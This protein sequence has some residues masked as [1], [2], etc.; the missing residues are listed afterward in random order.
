[1]STVM[2]FTSLR[3]LLAMNLFASL[4][5]AAGGQQAVAAPDPSPSSPPKLFGRQAERLAT[6]SASALPSGF[7]DERVA[8]GK[9]LPAQYQLGTPTAVAFLPDGRLLVA[10]K[11][12]RLRLVKD[13]LVQPVPA[14]DWTAQVY[15]NGDAGLI[16]VAVDQAFA[17]NGYIYL[18]YTSDNPREGRVARFTMTGDTAIP[19]S[20]LVLLSTIADHDTH[21]IDSVR[22]GADGLLYASDGD[23][24]PF[25]TATIDATRS[26]QADQTVGKVYRMTTSGQGIPANPFWTGNPNDAASK[27]FGLGLRN[28]FRFTVRP[29]G[30]VIVGDVGWNTWEE[31]DRILPNSSNHNYGWPCYEGGNN[32]SQ[33][34]PAFSNFAVCQ[35][36]LPQ[37]TG[38]VTAPV[39]AYDHTV[40]SS[41]TGGMVYDGTAFPAPYRGAYFF[42]DYS[43][44][45][46]NYWPMDAAG[47]FVG[48][49]ARFATIS[50]PVDIELGPDG[51][52]YYI[53]I[54]DNQVRR[55][56]YGAP[57]ACA[58]GN[59]FAQYYTNQTWSG[60][61]AI[62]RCDDTIDND[63]GSSGPFGASPTDHFSVSWS[64]SKY[65]TK[66]AN[67][68]TSTSDDGMQVWVD[69][70]F[71]LDNGGDHVPITKSAAI[72]Y[73]AGGFH[74]VL[75]KY[76]ENAGGAVAK[77]AITSANKLPTPVITQPATGAQFS[78]GQVIN[79]A[80]S[81]T[82][83]E[84]GTLSGAA[85][86]WNVILHH[87]PP[88]PAGVTDICHTHPYA[89]FSG[90]GGTVTAP[91]TG[92]DWVWLEITLT[93]I[94][95]AGA[96]ATARAN[97][98]PSLC[99]NEA[100]LAHY[101]TNQVWSGT[102]AI[103]RCDASIDNDWG[104]GGPFG[105]SPVDNFSAE[106]HS[107]RF[108]AAGTSTLSSSSDD[109]MQV[110][111]DGDLVI[112]NNGIHPVTTKTGTVTFAAAGYHDVFVRYYEA[113]G[114]AVAKITTPAPNGCS[115]G[116]PRGRYYTN[117][118]WS[119]TPAINRCD[120]AID[121]NW[122][123]GGPFGVTP[124]DHYSVE[125]RYPRIFP[126]G[127][128]TLT[129]TADDGMQVWVDG[130]LVVDNGGIH[131]AVT[132]TGTVNYSTA[133]YHDILIRYYEND[134]Q[135]L[136]QFGIT[137]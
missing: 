89:W 92:G 17:T 97:V 136:A 118:N 24:S 85:L 67:T 37:G 113:G 116:Q 72:T 128:S 83:P 29:D 94:D 57:S 103:T 121:F 28:P 104:G 76:Y 98:F 90:S 123:G 68:I 88:T 56:A 52:V 61:P 10:E 81:A 119:G 16:G 112:D 111:V 130:K 126:A 32:G 8:G 4:W 44:N 26:Q 2:R 6:T 137:P 40:G 79:V 41:V 122:G 12:G 42:G 33:T 120:A 20:E 50:S 31:I 73:P 117:Q 53:S 84:D 13:S 59:Y 15:S 66:G 78:S 109:G 55:I 134:G 71:V 80:G 7:R 114:Q 11:P 19:T 131:P 5:L 110:W 125:W 93:A 124:V 47:N 48:Q 96:G 58:S 129:T 22:I 39:F 14:L 100:A 63:W 64:G 1:M 35:S 30:S 43:K 51:A 9:D 69:G 23:S 54:V 86:Q 75:V 18:A 87:C 45:W 38:A 133:G 70:Q 102:P 36:L 34:Q 74:N 49:P 127:T 3:L 107:A 65:F 106:W 115:Y 105:A 77:L 108:F 21:M 27:V 82:D 91:D 101:Y 135:A 95:S 132:K 99:A 62:A 60:T 46:L 25:D